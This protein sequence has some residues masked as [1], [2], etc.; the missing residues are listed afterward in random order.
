[1]K[2][3]FLC[4]ETV[5]CNWKA[6]LFW[7]AGLP[8]KARFCWRTGSSEG[9]TSPG[10]SLSRTSCNLCKDD[11][12]VHACAVCLTNSIGGGGGG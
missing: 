11:G 8:W 12:V 4:S 3:K 5:L 6:G 1:M 2:C 9:R 10:Y 7:M